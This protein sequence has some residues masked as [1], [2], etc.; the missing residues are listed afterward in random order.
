MNIVYVAVGGQNH[1]LVERCQGPGERSRFA[2]LTCP[3]FS[4]LRYVLV[5][6]IGSRVTQAAQSFR[7][8]YES[9]H[10]WADLVMLAQACHSISEVPRTNRVKLYQLVPSCHTPSSWG[11]RQH[12]ELRL[13]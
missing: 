4:S 1:L 12:R 2:S 11:I 7:F 8:F 6:L 9:E 10:F 5:K 3:G 13:P